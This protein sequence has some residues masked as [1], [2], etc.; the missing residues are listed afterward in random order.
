MCKKYFLFLSF[1]FCFLLQINSQV[2]FWVRFNNK[3]GTPY[4]INNPSAFLSTKSILRRTF[5]NIP[6]NSSDLPVN[7]SYVSQIDNIQNVTVLYV[8]KW[9][10]GIVISVPSSTSTV[11]ATINSFSFVAGSGQVNFYKLNVPNTNATSNFDQ[12]F[13]SKASFLSS[14][15]AYNYGGSY[16]QNKQ[17]NLDCLH[18]KGFKGRGITIAVLDGGFYH[19]DVNPV[20]D[21]IR[22]YG[23]ILGTR[24]FVS[25][26]TSVYEDNSHGMSVLSC[27]AANKPGLIVGSA[28]E[29]FYWLLRTEDVDTESLSEEYNWVRGAE[30]ADSVGADILTT[31]L[32]YT[33]FDN[34]LQ[35][36]SY[37]S[38]NGKTTPISIASTMAARKGMFVLTAAGNEGSGSWLYIAAPGDADSICTVGAIDSLGIVGSFSSIGPTFDGRIKPDLVARG[39]GAWISFSNGQCGQANGTSFSTP[40]LAGAIACFWQ[41]HSNYN[42]IKLLDTLRKISSNALSPNNSKGWGIPNMCVIPVS[43]D[44]KNKVDENFNFFVLPNPFNSFFN[45]KIQSNYEDVHQIQITNLTGEILFVQN[46]IQKEIK[47]DATQFS[48]GVYFLKI[49]NSKK[50]QIKKIIKY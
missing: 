17:L 5:H 14:T 29:A 44:E 11:L 35:N 1:S 49:N 24:D 8:S 41:S 9:L 6:L 36:H 45:I 27:M 28:P 4:S 19:V 39:V 43:I 20:F 26:G 18:N 12:Q 34:S 3:N 40:I 10:N 21:S 7:P 15:N 46:T 22:A 47:I 2:K 50:Y 16:W 31:S 25:G 48:E 42:N 32:G 33:E 13:N 37:S 23:R 30:F 38:L